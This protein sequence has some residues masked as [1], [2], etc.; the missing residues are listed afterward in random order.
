[1][2]CLSLFRPFICT[3]NKDISQNNCLS[4]FRVCSREHSPFG[5][6][7]AYPGTFL[8]QNS[9]HLNSYYIN[10][11]KYHSHNGVSQI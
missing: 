2:Y 1:M 3:L 10:N 5:L 4:L 9:K 8:V 6:I 7:F 11:S